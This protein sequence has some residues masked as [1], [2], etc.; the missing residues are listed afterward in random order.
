MAGHA[1][2]VV[3]VGLDVVVDE[4]AGA[5]VVE[6]AFGEVEAVGVDSCHVEGVGDGAG[7]GVVDKGA[8]FGDEVGDVVEKSVDVVGSVECVVERV[9][10]VAEGR[11]W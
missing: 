8:G 3:Q 11:H 2:V 5:G 4:C 7:A 6:G 9:G 1:E 10:D